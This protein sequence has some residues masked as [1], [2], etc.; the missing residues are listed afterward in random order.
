ML[1]EKSGKRII[2]VRNLRIPGKI[3]LHNKQLTIKT[4]TRTA[5]YG[6]SRNFNGNSNADILSVNK[7]KAVWKAYHVQF[8]ALWKIGT[9]ITTVPRY[10]GIASAGHDQEWDEAE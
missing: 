9:P 5:V 4:P 10:I 8:V 2:A 7:S 1:K 3:Y 6:G